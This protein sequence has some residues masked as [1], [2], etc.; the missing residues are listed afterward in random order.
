VFLLR[1]EGLMVRLVK[2]LR[3]GTGFCCRIPV[4]PNRAI[5]K[6]PGGRHAWRPA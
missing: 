3:T 5:T 4:T 1:R 6:R 2:D